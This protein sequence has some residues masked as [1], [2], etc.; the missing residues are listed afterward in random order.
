MAPVEGR[1]PVVEVVSPPET[2]RATIAEIEAEA[3]IYE[4]HPQVM[5]IIGDRVG[6][7]VG[8]CRYM[9][10]LDTYRRGGQ[11]RLLILDMEPTGI[12][13]GSVELAL[14]K[15]LEHRLTRLQDDRKTVHDALLP[16]R[17]AAAKCAERLAVYLRDRG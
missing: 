6:V 11:N 9:I 8:D 10:H 4:D 16:A 1:G 17:E 3:I 12:P 2:G 14:A 5:E 13:V 15:I 7:T